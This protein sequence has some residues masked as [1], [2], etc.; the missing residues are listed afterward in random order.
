YLNSELDPQSK[1]L[2]NNGSIQ[3][4]NK[5]MEFQVDF[6]TT[7]NLFKML[8]MS[9]QALHTGFY[10]YQEKV[11]VKHIFIDNIADVIDIDIS[12]FLNC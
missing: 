10:P 3:I 4:N 7:I 5:F 12:V 8:E 11:H 6:N 1:I 2:E 9:K